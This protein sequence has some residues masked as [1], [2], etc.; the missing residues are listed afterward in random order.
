MIFVVSLRV[1]RGSRRAEQVLAGPGGMY[2]EED[3]ATMRWLTRH[4][5]PFERDEIEW[6]TL[7]ELR[8]KVERQVERRR[9]APR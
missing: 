9:S 2:E 6:L 7:Q 3:V 8:F 4:P 5:D 1:L